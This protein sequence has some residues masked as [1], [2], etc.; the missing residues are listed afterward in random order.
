MAQTSPLLTQKDTSPANAA[1]IDGA[2]YHNN[3]GFSSTLPERDSGFTDNDE[4]DHR[5]TGNFV[6]NTPAVRDTSLLDDISFQYELYTGQVVDR[7]QRHTTVATTSVASPHCHWAST[8]EY[9]LSDTQNL[10]SLSTPNHAAAG[11][12]LQRT[13]ADVQSAADPTVI[14][15]GYFEQVFEFENYNGSMASQTRDL[16]QN[17]GL[18]KTDVFVRPQ[19]GLR[20]STLGAS[21]SPPQEWS[22]R[23]LGR[24]RLQDPRSTQDVNDWYH[25]TYQLLPP[26]P[27]DVLQQAYDITNQ[28][29]GTPDGSYARRPQQSQTAGPYKGFHDQAGII[30]RYEY[31]TTTQHA[32]RSHTEFPVEFMQ[33]HR[34]SSLRERRSARAEQGHLASSPEIGF[35]TQLEGSTQAERPL[36]I[37]DGSDNAGN[38]QA[39]QYPDGLIWPQ[40]KS[41]P[42]PPRSG[43][44]AR[45]PPIDQ[46]RIQSH[47][48]GPGW[49]SGCDL[50]AFFGDDPVPRLRYTLSTNR[51]RD[52]RKD[53]NGRLHMVGKQKGRDPKYPS[54]FDPLP[55]GTPLDNAVR[56]YPN[57]VWGNFLRVLMAEG[58]SEKRVYDLLPADFAHR[59]GSKADDKRPWNYLQQAYGRE[60]DKQM[61]ES[62]W[63]KRRIDKRKRVENEA[64]DNDLAG[65][66]LVETG[67]KGKGKDENP[68]VDAEA[69]CDNALPFHVRPESFWL[70]QIST[71]MPLV[72]AS[73]DHSPVQEYRKALSE[74]MEDVRKACLRTR[75]QICG[76]IRDVTRLK[77]PA[78]LTWPTK[79]QQREVERLYQA[80]ADKW[81]K[82][83]WRTNTDDRH[84][85][86]KALVS[87]LASA[88]VP[89]APSTTQR[90]EADERWFAQYLRFLAN[91]EKDLTIELSTLSTPAIAVQSQAVSHSQW[92]E[93]YPQRSAHRAYETALLDTSPH[94][95]F[96]PSQQSS[97]QAPHLGQGYS[98][99][100]PIQSVGGMASAP[101]RQT[102][103]GT[104]DAYSSGLNSC[105]YE[106]GDGG[107]RTAQ[108]LNLG[109][110]AMDPTRHIFNGGMISNDGF[111]STSQPFHGVHQD[112]AI[113]NDIFQPAW[114]AEPL[115]NDVNRAARYKNQKSGDFSSHLEQ[116][117]MQTPS[118][119][120]QAS[121]SDAPIFKS[122]NQRSSWLGYGAAEQQT[123]YQAPNFSV[124]NSQAFPAYIDSD[125][126]QLSFP[127]Q[128]R[129]E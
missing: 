72:E 35:K 71:N 24:G 67:K 84:P 22:D 23:E 7:L 100:D 89:S 12:K 75:K 125:S 103:K 126:A 115:V 83:Y 129:Q 109:Q 107:W 15:Q 52:G 65:Q 53:E 21:Q 48:I 101:A 80:E 3:D 104:Q 70:T 61:E 29:Y 63:P 113:F 42:E 20:V 92:T 57:H 55:M 116:N 26:Q 56:S 86:L 45:L 108:K 64:I 88:Y 124:M 18:D 74:Q 46:A 120:A 37:E 17:L 4:I 79:R 16:A 90:V 27:Q 1:N 81:L 117:V 41:R 43:P 58:F 97:Q 121:T 94:F 98:S 44:L 60:I 14:A 102:E 123:L 105:A 54:S 39:F 76:R 9:G 28:A 118:R 50:V 93:D 38:E 10:R 25:T 2:A 82:A 62:N 85:N 68:Q 36:E 122:R 128:M 106:F 47:T 11:T 30:G 91:W 111:V 110:H 119:D 77:N 73:D 31:E 5:Y 99:S 51:G 127:Q 8:E 34:P 78:F 33:D 49:G 87:R 96:Q 95:Q 112:A 6:N 114:A 69:F 32:G 40:R 66:A 19:G 13:L 59:H